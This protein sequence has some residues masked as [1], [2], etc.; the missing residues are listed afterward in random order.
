MRIIICMKQIRY[1]YA[2]T[3]RDPKR[4][5]L[6][7]EDDIYRINP[8]DEVALELALRVKETQDRGEA[9]ILTQGPI[10]AEAEL[11]R[12][13]AMGAEKIYRIKGTGEMD[14]WRKSALLARAANE[15]GADLILCGK[16]SLDTRNGQTG[17][18]MARRLGMPFVS[19][20]LDL[21]VKDNG[22]I[23]V[24]RAAGQGIRQM[25]ECQYPAVFSVDLGPH[26]P[27]LPTYEDKKRAWSVKIQPLEYSEENVQNMTISAGLFSPR[28]RPK[29]VPP[30]DS[31]LEAFDRI[32]QLLMG[33]RIEKKGTILRGTPDSQ[34]HGIMTFLEDH[35]FLKSIKSP[36]HD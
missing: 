28:P 30:P 10:I 6:A 24:R 25:I 17:A 11:R 15:L 33:S 2:R 19:G 3:G 22:S 5:F 20:I 34:V 36:K 12:C 23:E 14:P 8:Y 1:T 18:F 26:V 35:G 31:R 27:R 21:T 4:H 32:D 9:V 7:P 29:K 16:E 13:L